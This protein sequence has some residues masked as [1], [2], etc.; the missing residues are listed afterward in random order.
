[1]KTLQDD[2]DDL[3]RMVDTGAAKDA[4]RSQIRLISREVAALQA[5]NA[6]L[7][8]AHAQLYALH[9]ELHAARNQESRDAVWEALLEKQKRALE[10][11]RSKTIYPDAS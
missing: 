6:G 4:I 7:V 11:T 8:E 9:Q 5:R 1:M 2:I 3:D 10:L